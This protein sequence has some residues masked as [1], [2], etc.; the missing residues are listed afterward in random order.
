MDP[1]THALSGALAGRALSPS[2]AERRV[3]RAATW[4][5]V[6]AVLAPD[7]D[8]LLRLLADPLTYLNW[9]RT[10]THSLPLLPLWAGLLAWL[11]RP[12]RRLLG[13]RRVW[14]LC[15]AGM[16]L[17]VAG[18]LITPFGTAILWPLSGRRFSL[19]STFVVDPLVTAPLAAGLLA[20]VRWGRRRT[21]LAALAVAAAVVALEWGLRQRA[22]GIARAH[23][24]AL[25]LPPERARALPQPLSPLRWKLVVETPTG[26]EVAHVRLG[27]G[28]VAQAA[29]GDGWLGRFASAYRPPGMLRWEPA[30]HPGRGRRHPLAAAAWARPELE[31]FR[32]FAGLPFVLG[33]GADAAGR[34]CVWLSDLRFVVPGL[35]PPFRFEVCRAGGG[36]GWSLRPLP[37]RPRG[38]QAPFMAD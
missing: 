31:G 8:Y 6:A 34:A 27:A 26:Y 38:T 17:H 32:R 3:A 24:A 30:E 25:G 35:P 4:T 37:R 20:G 18:D 2:G 33:T 19:E 21:A 22:L 23:A 12:A 11:L 16:A 10:F 14:A 7:L 1:F 13:A 5:G 9:H 29:A 15:V 36:K 28:G